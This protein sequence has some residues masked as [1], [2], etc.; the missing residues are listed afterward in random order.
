MS[1]FPPHPLRSSRLNRLRS[2]PR[3]SGSDR[4][5]RSPRLRTDRSS[6]LRAWIGLLAILL[7]LAPL[8]PGGPV[9]GI[10]ASSDL[11]HHELVFQIDPSAGSL[12]GTDTIRGPLGE[13]VEISL[14]SSLTVTS[15]SPAWHLTERP[16]PA[17]EE[18]VGINEPGSGE[19]L[20]RRRY[21][22][23]RAEEID[24]C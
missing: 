11:I 13:K 21:L 8:A 2:G 18:R 3:S 17:S 19:I 6:S 4:T 1:A 20:P 14:H 10:E 9:R 22:A 7:P 16:D 23:E 12:R 24:P 15:E 5:D